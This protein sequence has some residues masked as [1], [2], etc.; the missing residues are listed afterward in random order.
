LL[1]EMAED[2]RWR[3]DLARRGFEAGS[4]AKAKT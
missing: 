4:G 3:I 2:I 1:A